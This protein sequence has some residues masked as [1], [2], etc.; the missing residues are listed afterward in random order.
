MRLSHPL[1]T[2]PYP[3]AA[4][5]LILPKERVATLIPPIKNKLP[6]HICH[7]ATVLL[8]PIACKGGPGTYVELSS[9]WENIVLFSLD[10]LT[11]ATPARQFCTL[12][13]FID[14]PAKW[15]TQFREDGSRK[16]GY[17]STSADGTVLCLRH[18]KKKERLTVW[19]RATVSNRDKSHIFW[20]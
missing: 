8:A 3:G 5:W 17:T 1:P 15:I 18:E 7:W 11:S 20:Y 9:Q 2:G 14:E 13:L 10:R 19:T 6:C 12:F 16:C 4:E